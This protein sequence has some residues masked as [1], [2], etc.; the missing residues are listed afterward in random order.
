MARVYEA[1]RESLAGVAPKVA[2]KVILPEY[3]ADETFQQLFV[4]EARIGSQLQHQNLVQIQDFDRE[5]GHFYLVMEYVEGVTLRRAA[6][7]CRRNGMPIPLAV[8]AELG[9]QVSEGLHYAH[10]ARSEDGQ[11]LHLVHRDI[12]PSNLILNAQGVVK[13]LDFGISK[14]LIAAEKRGTVKGTWGYMAPEQ[15]AAK[16]VDA[17]ADQY[18]VAAVLYELAM[19]KSLFPEKEPRELRRLMSQDEAARRANRLVGPHAP[20]V[21]VLLR[22]LQRDPAARFQDT[23]QMALALGRLTPDPVLAREQVLHFHHTVSQLAQGQLPEPRRSASTMSRAPSQPSHATGGLPVAAGDAHG[24]RPGVAIGGP[25]PLA[26]PRSPWT[27]GAVFMSGLAILVLGFVG[28]TLVLH[29]ADV[30]PELV[31]ATV[32]EAPVEEPV[33]AEV[34]EPVEEPVVEPEPVV[35]PPVVTKTPDPVRPRAQPAPEKTPDSVVEPE[36]EPVRTTRSSTTASTGVLTVSSLPRSK[37]IVDGSFVRYTPLYEHELPAGAHVVRLETD[38]GRYTQFRV[39]VSGGSE[40]RR[41]WHFEK[42][43]WVEN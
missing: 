25:P 34:E 13:V 17:A 20:L 35:A 22:A 28:V 8:I 33:V 38:D 16:D 32:V 31:E 10:T 12:K 4:N 18:G 41:I 7:L 42:G 37:V 23:G 3:A 19:L 5:S 1:R 14:A 36:P 43:E 26:K 39:D 27:M 11:Q 6:S 29:E 24:P 21:P 2:V 15:A 9:R 30:K 40:V